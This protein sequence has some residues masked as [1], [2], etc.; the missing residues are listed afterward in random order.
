MRKLALHLQEQK[1][2]G[3]WLFGSGGEGPALSDATRRAAIETINDATGGKLRLLVGISAESTGRA[4]E[5]YAAIADLEMA[6]TFATPPIYYTYR[7]PELVLYFK[8]LASETGRDFF[9]YHNPFFAHSTLTL[10]SLVELANTEGIVGAKD[11]TRDL[12]FTQRFIASV[13]DDFAIFE[14]EEVL[15]GPALLAGADGLVSVISTMRPQP[16]LDLIKA[17]DDGDLAGARKCQAVIFELVDELGLIGPVTNSEFIGAVKARLA[18]A[19]L[20]GP[21]MTAPFLPAGTTTG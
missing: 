2:D 5:R 3:V 20:A 4:L 12:A 15:A 19:G 7:Q 11:S 10:E 18:Q 17:V 14:G 13:G 16:F 1:V 21:A 8:R 6:G 9:I